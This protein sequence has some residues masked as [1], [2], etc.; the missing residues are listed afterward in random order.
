MH[1]NPSCYSQGNLEMSKN[2]KNSVKQRKAKE[3]CDMSENF[4]SEMK[5]F[6]F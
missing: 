2:L 6:I 4:Y 1:G 5:V 3:F